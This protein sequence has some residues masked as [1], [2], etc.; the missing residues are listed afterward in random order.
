MYSATDGER[1]LPD[2]TY[3][4]GRQQVERRSIYGTHTF[5]AAVGRRMAVVVL[6]ET[7]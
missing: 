5:A 1:S 2:P 3:V 4:T 6:V 7:A